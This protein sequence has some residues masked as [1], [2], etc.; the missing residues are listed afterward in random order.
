MATNAIIRSR[1]GLKV[2]GTLAAVGTIIGAWSVWQAAAADKQTDQSLST[3]MRKK[4]DASSKVLEGLTT[5]DSDL[6]QE[7][8]NILI[9]LSKAEKWQMLTDPEYRAFSADFRNTAKKL[10]DAAAKSNFDNAALQWFD[11][12]KGCIECHQHVRQSRAA[13]K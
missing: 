1:I 6:V 3:F 4:L 12:T 5:E 8:A 11:V 7:G 13:K 9:E 10:A 2:L